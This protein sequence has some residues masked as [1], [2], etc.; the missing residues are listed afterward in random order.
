MRQGFLGSALT[1]E[2][3]IATDKI[4]TT[5]PPSPSLPRSHSTLPVCGLLLAGAAVVLISL[6]WAPKHT[7]SVPPTAPL[8]NSSSNFTSSSNDSSSDVGKSGPLPRQHSQHTLFIN[9]DSSEIAV[10]APPPPS[11]PPSFSSTAASSV[12]AAATSSTSGAA[13]SCGVAGSGAGSG[14]SNTTSTGLGWKSPPLFVESG[15]GDGF[16]IYYDYDRH[17]DSGA[18]VSS[19]FCVADTAADTTCSLNQP[20]ATSGRM[21][22]V[23]AAVPMAPSSPPSAAAAKAQQ[24]SGASYSPAAPAAALPISFCADS[25]SCMGGRG[26]HTTPSSMAAVVQAVGAAHG[27]DA[28]S[29][30]AYIAGSEGGGGGTASEG[31]MSPALLRQR[32]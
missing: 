20:T 30:F 22:S 31:D 14:G 27:A 29:Q 26:K 4:S 19:A 21:T 15:D 7:S 17:L 10:G 6:S 13:V 5:V 8:L 16:G 24:L 11:P 1:V 25:T 9:S 3:S 28:S 23:A 18:D 32:H 2:C 12:T